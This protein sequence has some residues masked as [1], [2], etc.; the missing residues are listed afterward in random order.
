M[1]V[2][3]PSSTPSE[4]VPQRA[5]RREDLVTALV[6][7]W[8]I[9]ALFSDGWAH[10]NVPELEGFFTP[11]HGALY[12]AFA[13]A[14]LWVAA[15]GL[16]RGVGLTEGLRQPMLAVRHL[17]AGYPLAAVGVVVFG[18]GGVLDLLWH[19]A[20]GVEQGI[21]ALLSPSHLTL[22]VGGML[23]LTAPVRGA[24]TAPDGAAGLRARSA[25][26]LS[27]SLSASL[28]AFFLLYASTFLRP[29]VDE[30]FVRLPENA[31]GHDAAEAAAVLTSTS[32]LVTTA[33]LVIPLVLLAKRGAV[34]RG[35]V[36]LL[37]VPVVW[38]SAALAEFEQLAIAVAVTGAAVVADIVVSRLDALPFRLR[39]PIVGAALPGLLWPAA[40]VAVA[41]T[42][43][44][45]YPVA[46]WTGVLVLTV[47]TGALLGG[48]ARPLSTPRPC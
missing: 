37:V 31:P 42:D 25:E 39:L 11:W 38:L 13:A 17:P 6:G 7:A 43:A 8:L 44:L 28:A 15:L 3:S 18:L 35:A 30:A 26:L 36:V 41:V 20:F 16:R 47:L 21:D 23:L 34:P 29:G 27:L 9:L 46:L 19:T 12:S 22:F 40:M 45:R 5:H 14:T 33:L 2:L 24:W 48:V 1:S 4:H 10:F 32:Y